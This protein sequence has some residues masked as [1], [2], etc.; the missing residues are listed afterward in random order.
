M[1]LHD[2]A[3][4]AATPTHAFFCPQKRERS[5]AECSL[6]HTRN[7]RL[8][9]VPSASLAP[10]IA[11]PPRWRWMSTHSPARTHVWARLLALSRPPPLPRPAAAQILHEEKHAR[12]A[13]LRP[14]NRY[15]L[16]CP[17]PL[18]RARQ[19]WG[20]VLCSVT[21]FSPPT[22]APPLSPGTLSSSRLCTL[23]R[24]SVTDSP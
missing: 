4:E 14:A 16:R 2:L 8:G 7:A 20:Q 13:M 10:L 23:G 3:G 24:P 21:S 18:P 19:R 6:R 15:E 17:S 5:P 11:A 12:A 9:H 1:C 22:P